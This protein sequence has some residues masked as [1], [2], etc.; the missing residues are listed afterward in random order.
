M[1][2]DRFLGPLHPAVD[3]ITRSLAFNLNALGV[4]TPPPSVLADALFLTLLLPILTSI[5]F[6]L[7]SKLGKR[8]ATNAIVIVGISGDSDEPA[9]GKTTLYK[10]LRYGEQPKHGT[11]SS[12]RV[13]DETFSPIGATPS[14]TMR[15]VDFPGHARLRPQL[16]SYL[17]QA[18]GIVQVVDASRF[19]AQARRDAQLLL[20]VL[21]ERCV[22]E[23]GTPVLVFL[24]KSEVAGATTPEVVKVRLEAE[25][26]RARKA[27]SATLRS[28]AVGGARGEEGGADADREDDSVPLGYENEPFAFE[29]AAGPVKFASGSA[30][31]SDVDGVMSFARSCFQ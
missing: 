13:N 16:P 29:H 24:N 20:A 19:S 31:K 28:A 7:S 25:L 8:D 15:W 9:V 22:A 10:C 3:S 2:V 5:I 30:L 12:M 21:T 11:V 14:L 17:A 27:A 23:R 1:V 4:P 26:E 18:R 6:T